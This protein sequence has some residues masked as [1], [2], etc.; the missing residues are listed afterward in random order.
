VASADPVTITSGSISIPSSNVFSPI[1]LVG[2]D[3]VS[4]FLF[5]GLES[6]LSRVSVH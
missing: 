4:S 3:G 2:T 5:T 6:D 1:Q